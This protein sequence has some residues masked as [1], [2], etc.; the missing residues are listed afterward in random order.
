MLLEHARG[1]PS[2]GVFERALERFHSVAALLGL[3]QEDSGAH[4]LR[5][6]LRQLCWEQHL[7]LH[8]QTKRSKLSLPP[9]IGEP[10]CKSSQIAHAYC[11]A[12]R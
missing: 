7:N 1:P 6:H 2:I 11:A 4:E 9:P 3:G 5:L 8:A 10:F 12:Y